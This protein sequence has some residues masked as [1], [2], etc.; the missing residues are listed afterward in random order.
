MSL[1]IYGCFLLVFILIDNIFMVVLRLV[2]YFIFY[3]YITNI[4]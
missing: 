4:L 3:I 2:I 1:I